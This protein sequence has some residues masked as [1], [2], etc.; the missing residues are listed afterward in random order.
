MRFQ[1]RSQLSCSWRFRFVTTGDRHSPGCQHPAVPYATRFSASPRGCTPG[2]LPLLAPARPSFCL[3]LKK[4]AKID[5]MPRPTMRNVIAEYKSY[6]LV[7]SSIST[8]IFSI[9]LLQTAKQGTIVVARTM[10]LWKALVFLRMHNQRRPRPRTFDRFKRRNDLKETPY[11]LSTRIDHV[12]IDDQAC[13]AP[14]E[15]VEIQS[16]SS[17]TLVREADGK[18]RI[19]RWFT[20]CAL[21]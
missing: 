3:G 21:I 10:P 12:V 2:A 8:S 6:L 4:T 17:P 9:A 11:P 19:R 15:L 18:A 14:V 20:R 5:P 7:A 13:S 16:D 1:V